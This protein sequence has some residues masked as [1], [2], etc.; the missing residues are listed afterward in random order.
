MFVN[1]Y[2]LL[3]FKLSFSRFLLSVPPKFPVFPTS[4]PFVSIWSVA[5]YT[6][7]QQERLAKQLQEQGTKP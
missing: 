6:E 7:T 2:Q 4:V 1:Q 3:G 5:T